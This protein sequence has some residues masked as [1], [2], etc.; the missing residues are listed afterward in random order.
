[1]Q[2]VVRQYLLGELPL[3]EKE[4]WRRSGSLGQSCRS[5]SSFSSGS[6]PQVPAEDAVRWPRAPVG[7]GRRGT[8]GKSSLVRPKTAF[9]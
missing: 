1:V 3:G 2:S 8:A 6:G 9:A 4:A 7:Y 5:S